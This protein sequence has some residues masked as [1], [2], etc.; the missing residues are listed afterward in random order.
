MEEDGRKVE[1][2]VSRVRRR[3]WEEGGRRRLER[4]KGKERRVYSGK[5]GRGWGSEEGEGESRSASPRKNLLYN[6]SCS[7]PRA[8]W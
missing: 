2:E 3:K 7:L 8:G 4:R 6:L 5:D 1:R